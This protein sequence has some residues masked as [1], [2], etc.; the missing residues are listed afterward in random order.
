MFLFH[1]VHF[2]KFLVKSKPQRSY[3]KRFLYIYIY[4]KKSVP[5]STGLVKSP[6]RYIGVSF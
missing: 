6:H 5:R 2:L 1:L 4:I 3:K